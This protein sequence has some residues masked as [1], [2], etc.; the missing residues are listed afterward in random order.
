MKRPSMSNFAKNFRFVISLIW[1]TSPKF[2]C[3]KFAVVLVNTVSPFIMI[4]FPKLIIDS[5]IGGVDWAETFRL[6]V[7]MG[8]A[9]LATTMLS[10]FLNTTA[11][12]YGDTIQYDLVR[13]Y[14]R[15]VMSLDYE[16]LEDPPFS[17]CLKK[18]RAALT[19]MISSTK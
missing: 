11:Q 3:A 15:K 17:T 5:I 7:I 16:D 9:L 10:T 14:G 8:V 6:V 2:I 18:Q 12:K 13:I 1:Q 4:I 19:C